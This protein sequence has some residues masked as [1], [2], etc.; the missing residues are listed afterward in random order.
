MTHGNFGWKMATL[1]EKVNGRTNLKRF[2]SIGGNKC[3]KLKYM[4]QF[5]IRVEVEGEMMKLTL[6][7]NIDKYIV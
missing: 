3:N 2:K 4:G 6:K 1:D 7:I 5:D